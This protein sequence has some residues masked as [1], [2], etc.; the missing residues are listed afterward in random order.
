MEN[1]TKIKIQS[2]N[3]MLVMPHHHARTV[4]STDTD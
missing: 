4:I 3:W 2:R 1:V